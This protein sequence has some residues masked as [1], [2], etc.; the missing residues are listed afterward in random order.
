MMRL[1]LCRSVLRRAALGAALFFASIPAAQ[2]RPWMVCVDPGHPSETSAGATANG[3]SENRLNWQV[4]LKLRE[5]LLARGIGVQMTKARE[6]Q[7]V[8]NRRRAEIANRG[9]D[10]F[11]RLHC[12]EGP[13]RGFAW[14]YPDRAGRKGGVTGPPRA[15]QIASREAALLINRAMIPVLRGHLASNPYPHRR[16]RPTSEAARAAS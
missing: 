3:L 1:P 4:A 7:L 6:N 13:G 11:I 5:K 10:L 2:A 8:T 9:S 16:R 14:Y 12:D 15:V